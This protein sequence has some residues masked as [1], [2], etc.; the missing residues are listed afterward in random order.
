MLIS[1]LT[2]P[3]PEG[4]GGPA[5]PG[6]PGVPGSPSLPLG[7]MFPCREGVGDWGWYTINE[8][9]LINNGSRNTHSA[10]CE[11]KLDPSSFE[12]Y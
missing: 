7:P 5:G 4:P 8:G 3:S 2:P 11:Y 1:T 6:F 12:L 10:I 9:F